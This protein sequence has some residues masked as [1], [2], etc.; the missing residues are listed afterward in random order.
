MKKKYIY[1]AF[2]IALVLGFVLIALFNQKKELNTA[3]TK[4][5]DYQEVMQGG[6]LKILTSYS[7]YSR[8]DEKKVELNKFIDFL[9]KEKGIN[10]SLTTENSRPIALQKL[11][12]GEIDLIAEKIV[13]TAKIDTAQFV[14]LNEEYCEPIYLVQRKDSLSIKSHFDLGGKEICLPKDSELELFVE[15]LSK[16]IAEPVSV[17]IDPLYA[18]EQLVLKVLNGKIDYTLCSAEEARYYSEQF[19]NLD[20]S[21]P[22]SFSL[23]R[24]WLVRKSSKDLCDS[25]NKWVKEFHHKQ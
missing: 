16:E 1:I 17:Q 25:L 4:I 15:H 19:P 5:R 12:S 14:A 6:T 11:L 3:R 10:A 7:A 22:I 24:A 2:A 9:Q 8:E 23:R 13:L 18:T 21:L 20:I